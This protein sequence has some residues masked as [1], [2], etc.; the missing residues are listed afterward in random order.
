MITNEKGS[1]KTLFFTGQCLQAR[2]SALEA[3]VVVEGDLCHDVVRPLVL[4]VV[5]RS[6]GSSHQS[7]VELV[8]VRFACVSKGSPIAGCW[9][10]LAGSGLPVSL[11]LNLLR[12]YLV[13][14]LLWKVVPVAND[15]A[16][17]P[18]V[19]PEHVV[20]LTTGVCSVLSYLD[21]SVGCLLREK[22]LTEMKQNSP[23]GR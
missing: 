17:L 3:S 9:E 20:N 12:I 18:W 21:P 8:R 7:T 23:Q 10:G 14:G 22:K 13:V 11:T 16:K 15:V 4:V 2:H 5:V 6:A 1:I 19:F